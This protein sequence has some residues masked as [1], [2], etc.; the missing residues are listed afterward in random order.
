MQ[1]SVCQVKP[2]LNFVRMIC[3]YRQFLLDMVLSPLTGAKI[4]CIVFSVRL[5]E[6]VRE[7]PILRRL[8]PPAKEGN[9]HENY[10]TQ[11]RGSRI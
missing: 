2:L 3:V 7:K 9:D 5:I 11:R 6:D 1:T 8:S 10:Q 4:W